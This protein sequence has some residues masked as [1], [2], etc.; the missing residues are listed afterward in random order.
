M[1]LHPCRWNFTPSPGWTREEAR[2]LKLCLL[3][4][5]IGKWVQILDTGL[6]PGKMIQQL[7][8]Q[9]QR[10]LGQQ[11]LAAYTGLRL[12]VDRIRADNEALTDAQVT[13]KAG[14]IINDGGKL[15]KEQKAA[16]QEAS[17]AKYALT[18][19]Q[20]DA[21]D[22]ALEEIYSART[23]D[24]EELARHRGLVEEL[25]KEV[26]EGVR[27]GREVMAGWTREEKVQKIKAL[28]GRLVEAQTVYRYHV[29]RE[30]GAVFQRRHKAEVRERDSRDVENNAGAA[31]GGAVVGSCQ[32]GAGKTSKPKKAQGKRGGKKFNTNGKTHSKRGKK[33]DPLSEDDEAGEGMDG[34]D[35]LDGMEVELDDVAM[36]VRE[37]RDAGHA[38]NVSALV[39]MGFGRRQALDALEEA[40]GSVEAAIEWLMVH[41][42]S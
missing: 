39:S 42:V 27:P 29:S 34:L 23:K 36:T 4:H 30:V 7:N 31:N 21:V 38:A 11:S 12:D 26:G 6:L 19:D 13:R 20:M 32:T 10:L 24:D 28:H 25:M 16:L 3:K 22:A 17:K 15:T 33:A 9:T 18:R 8:G 41:C 5:G 14:L 37:C 2:I 35:G 1:V 40:N